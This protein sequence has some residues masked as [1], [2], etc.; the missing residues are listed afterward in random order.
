MSHAD[1]F[2]GVVVFG[3]I[4]VQLVVHAMFL[5][6]RQQKKLFVDKNLA[7]KKNRTNTQ[8]LVQFYNMY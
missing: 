1:S 2:F 5:A 7:R 6:P 3:G 8:Y 4:V